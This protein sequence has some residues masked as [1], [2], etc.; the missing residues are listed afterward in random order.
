MLNCDGIDP[1][2]I[3]S[4]LEP[5]VASMFKPNEC[6][7]GYNL[8]WNLK[9]M[10]EM[11]CSMY[12][13]IP[14]CK[15]DIK[16]FKATIYGRCLE[17]QLAKL[18][19]SLVFSNNNLQTLNLS[20]TSRASLIYIVKQIISKDL[21]SFINPARPIYTLIKDEEPR[22]KLDL[23]ALLKGLEIQLNGT[24][25]NTTVAAPKDLLDTGEGEEKSA[26]KDSMDAL[27]KLRD[28][29]LSELH[30]MDIDIKT[31]STNTTSKNDTNSTD[32]SA[33]TEMTDRM[34]TVAS[35][36]AASVLAQVGG[37]D[38]SAKTAESLTN[39]I[40]SNVSIFENLIEANV[41]IP[42]TFIDT[43]ADLTVSDAIHRLEKI[44]DE[45][46]FTVKSNPNNATINSCPASNAST[47]D[48]STSDDTPIGDAA[49]RKSLI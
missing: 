20:I 18:K 12:N 3:K 1:D 26:Q 41:P 8:D 48:N 16:L 27:N 34:K 33:I 46:A 47:T 17:V 42:Q 35:K 2:T 22:A 32:N 14:K 45:Q 44:V 11:F 39:L 6:C 5:K 49:V 28:G 38:L 21:T 37:R 9:P 7:I 40:T 29:F 13:K 10:N 25:T 24:V 31:N 36:V 19:S 4:S 15:I 30:S 23:Y 43:V